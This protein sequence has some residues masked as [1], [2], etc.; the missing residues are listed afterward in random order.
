M[1]IMEGHVVA[2]IGPSG[3][4]KSTFLRCV[5]RMHEEVQ[6][7]RATGQ[8]FFKRSEYFTIKM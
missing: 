1:E 8:I 2:I 5:N 6:G 4:G 7:A 3:C